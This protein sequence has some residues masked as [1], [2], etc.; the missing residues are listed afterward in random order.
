MTWKTAFLAVFATL[1]AAVVFVCYAGPEPLVEIPTSAQMG[2]ESKS[3]LSDKNTVT[4]EK[5]PAKWWSVNVQA[6]YWSE[7]IFR[8]TNL[9][10]NSDGIAYQQAYFSAKGF[11]LGAWFASQLG[12]AVVP[13][14]TLVGE[15]G[16]GFSPF[17]RPGFKDFA[18]QTSFHELDIFSSYSHSF[19]PL[20]VTVG[21]V[22]FFIFRSAVDRFLGPNSEVDYAVPENEI[23]DRLFISLGTSKL[24][25]FGVSIVPT[26]TYYQT[27]YNHVD[28]IVTHNGELG[29]QN[30]TAIGC[31]CSDSTYELLELGFKRN[32]TLGGYLEGKVQAVIP[33]VDHVLRLQPTVLISYSAGDRSE[34]IPLTQAQFRA[35]PQPSAEPLYGFNH[36]QGGAELVLQINKWLSVTGFGNYAHHIAQPVAGTERDEEWGG[37]YVT[38]SF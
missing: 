11:T 9:T 12:T 37:G 7:Y 26:V 18:T 34:A 20:D 30:D 2:I 35:N 8:G 15:A 27:I 38:V 31:P 17:G 6:G 3:V 10:P 16:G 24:H 1:S 5:E 14:A 25:P 33:I 23:F 4:E 36:F 21:N 29:P 13:D 28:P 32:D 22:A 19:G